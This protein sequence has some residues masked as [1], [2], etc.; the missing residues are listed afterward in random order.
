MDCIRDDFLALSGRLAGF[1]GKK[2]KWNGFLCPGE[3]VSPLAGFSGI[4]DKALQE[5]SFVDSLF[6]HMYGESDYYACCLNSKNQMHITGYNMYRT[7]SRDASVDTA[8][9][10]SEA[11]PYKVFKNSETSFLLRYRGWVFTL[12]ARTSGSF[13]NSTGLVLY[14]KADAITKTF[15]RILLEDCEEYSID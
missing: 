15:E 8:M 12:R 11:E 9:T 3:A 14:Y 10:E 5:K 13:I 1:A 4:L 2:I 6:R 7:L